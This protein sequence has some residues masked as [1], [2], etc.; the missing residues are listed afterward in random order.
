MVLYK[1][2][3]VLASL[4]MTAARMGAGAASIASRYQPELPEQLRD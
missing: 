1:V 3:S 4:A 2:L